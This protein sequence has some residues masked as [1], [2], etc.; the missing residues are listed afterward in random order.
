VSTSTNLKQ[1]E[2]L[3]YLTRAEGNSRNWYNV[4]RT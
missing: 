2:K 4:V 3:G 1:L